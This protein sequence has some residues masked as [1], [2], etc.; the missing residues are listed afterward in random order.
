M[1]N[2]EKIEKNTQRSQSDFS[3]TPITG[4]S[5]K[6]ENQEYFQSKEKRFLHIISFLREKNCSW[7]CSNLTRD[8]SAH[9]CAL[10]NQLFEFHK[11]NS[12][13]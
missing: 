1:A 9:F 6:I 3:F 11:N 8:K 5:L 13:F 10:R 2:S 7:N 4:Y 12:K